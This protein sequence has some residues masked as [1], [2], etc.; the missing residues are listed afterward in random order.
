[1]P[2][3]LEGQ[4]IRLSDKIA[5][6]NHDIDDAIR[7]GILKQEEIPKE[8]IQV[9]GSTSGQR[10]DTLVKDVIISSM[11]K[12]AISMTNEVQEAFYNLRDFLYE[13]I[14][15]SPVAKQVEE[16]AVNLI[17]ELYHHFHSH[18]HLIPEQFLETMERLE[19]SK[20]RTVCD[21][22]AGMTDNY[23]IKMYEKYFIPQSWES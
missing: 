2:N 17:E 9:L 11:N 15:R 16:K 5:Y 18:F 14:Y 23:A 21:Y 1:M 19:L 8:F 10:I 3:T 22:I 4:V 6:I 12:P 13:N 7:G 20:E